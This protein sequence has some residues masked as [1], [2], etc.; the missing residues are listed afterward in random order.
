[1][2]FP[3]YQKAGFP[4]GKLSIPSSGN[5]LKS[6]R[7]YKAEFSDFKPE[8]PGVIIINP[9]Y[10]ERLGEGNELSHLYQLMGDVLKKNCQDA[11]AFILSGNMELTKHIGLKPENKIPLKNGKID[12]RLLHY[13]IRHG[14]YA[15]W[16]V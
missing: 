16:I 7:L 15:D 2:W 1:M 10:G 5:H 8:K 3:E 9:P 4:I 6:A 14:K 13:P 11:D 12:C